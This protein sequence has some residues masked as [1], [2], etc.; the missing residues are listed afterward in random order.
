LPVALVAAAAILAAPGGASATPPPAAE[1]VPGPVVLIGTGGLRWDDVDSSSPALWSFLSTGSVGTLAVRS[2]RTLACPV[3]GWLAVS[4]GKRAGDAPP[5][6][7]AQATSCRP[8][9]A[10]FA[11]GGGRAT[12]PRWD[13]YR[14]EAAASSFEATPGLLG[15]LL[16]DAGRS[17]A[18]VG[19]GAVIALATP[20][21]AVEHAWPGLGSG[22]DTA[23][24]RPTGS[25]P[26]G[27]PPTQ[28]ADDVRAAL[29]TTPDLLV[30]DVGTVSDL[31]DIPR[32]DQVRA[33]DTRLGLVAGALPASAT[34]LVASIADSQSIPA[35]LQLVA[36][37]GPAATAPDAAYATSLLG[38][39]STRQDGLAQ[40]TDLAPTTLAALNV[41]APADFVGSPLTSLDAGGTQASRLERLLDLGR[42]ALAVNPIVPWF[43]NGLVIAQLLL[44]GIATARLR[45][46]GKGPLGR[47][48][49]LAWLRRTAVVFACVPAAT[50][51]AN[52]VP[53]WRAAVPGLAV[54]GVVAAFVV[55]LALLALAGPWRGRPLAPLGVVGGITA[56]VLALDV[57][58]GSHLML[59]S[60]MGVQPVVAGRFYGFG[61]QPFALFA[62]G[63]LLLATA[64]ADELV[65]RD[66]R[67]Q[68]VLAVAAIGVTATVIDGTPGI[69]SDFGGPPALI[70]AFAVLGLL[71]AGIRITWRRVLLIAAA[72]VLTLVALSVA[73]WLRPAADRTHLGRFVQTVLDGGAWS[74]VSRK[75]QQNLSILLKPIALPIPFA[76]AFIAMVLAK[77]VAWGARPLQLTYDRAP[78]LRHGLLA[79]AVLLSLG[80]ALNDSGAAIPAVAATLAIPL[81]I[82]VSV[83]ALELDDLAAHQAAVERARRAGRR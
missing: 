13:T 14:A 5:D 20:D 61:N 83:R 27:P 57:L 30:V 15:R 80:L 79:L 45:R 34:V 26:A 63:C 46:A 9:E 4:A 51:L 7:G 59:S 54:T 78:V 47:R 24:A 33:I 19:P 71:V 68:A 10:A 36:A 62:T 82:A 67:R 58:T 29:A 48:R 55:P 6:G 28:L 41:P 16:R 52:L 3:D 8:P 76:V 74:V 32:A 50:F 65:H 44:Y 43:F 38:S 37:R 40:T 75:A 25:Q 66:R 70:P 22:Q 81:L 39:S 2:V 18:A 23:L 12:V 49:T 77:P 17:T 35:R 11:G 64:V 42:A 60:L 53:W 56:A 73:D 1:A 72:T 69:G 31:A 21:G